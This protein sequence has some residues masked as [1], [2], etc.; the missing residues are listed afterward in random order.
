MA[1]T[2]LPDPAVEALIGWWQTHAHTFADG[3]PGAHTVRYIPGRWAQISPWPQS[4]A[5]TD[6]S[7]D[8]AVS[9]AQVT[10]AVADALQREAFREALVATYVWGKGKRGTPACSGPATLRDVL[11]AE[12]LDTA[13]KTAV[14]ALREHGARQ[15]YAALLRKVPWF[16][17]AF[18]TKFLNFTGATV[19]PGSGPL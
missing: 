3:T 8:A 16:G 13:L 7:G 10:S 14:T 4:L 2:R 19:P 11:A 1:A 9:R 18:F 15:A 17:P 5:P 12:G 6:G